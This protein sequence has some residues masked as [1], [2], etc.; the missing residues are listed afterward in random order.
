MKGITSGDVII[1]A[2]SK[3]CGAA[4]AAS[5]VSIT[6][7]KPTSLRTINTQVCI[8]ALI[9]KSITLASVMLHK[10]R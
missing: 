5:I 7:A 8:V 4:A 2:Q 10:K 6:I 3:S 9:P 1:I